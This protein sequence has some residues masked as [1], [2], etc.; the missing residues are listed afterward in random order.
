MRVWGQAAA[1]LAS[2]PVPERGGEGVHG[3]GRLG[4]QDARDQSEHR[5]YPHTGQPD[6]GCWGPSG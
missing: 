6:A 3:S 5:D 4:A 1:A 2:V